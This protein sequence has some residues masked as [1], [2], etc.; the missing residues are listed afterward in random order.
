MPALLD[1]QGVGPIVAGILLAEVGNP[2]RFASA[3]HFASYCGAAP[4]ERGSGQNC[5]MQ[6]NPGGNGRLNWALHIVAMVRLGN[7]G[8]RSKTFLD[9]RRLRGK[10]Q[11]S[12]LRVLKTYIARELFSVMHHNIRANIEG[13]SP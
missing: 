4:V 8:G 12:A 3:N 5:R 13:L 6:V 2:K 9:K 7:D 1:V 11:R 10:S